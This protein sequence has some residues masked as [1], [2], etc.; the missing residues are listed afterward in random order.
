M[1]FDQLLAQTYEIGNP[2]S[3]VD[4]FDSPA[5]FAKFTSLER[6]LQGTPEETVVEPDPKN[7]KNQVQRIIPAKPPDWVRLERDCE[8]VWSQTR[9]LRVAVIIAV[10][11][12]QR[13]GF[14]GAR[15]ALDFLHKNIEKHWETIH[16]LQLG[17][18]SSDRFAEFN[19]LSTSL[20][21]DP[22]NPMLDDGKFVFH[23][24]RYRLFEVRGS[25]RVTYRDIENAR[26]GVREDD[27]PRVTR[28]EISTA[29]AKLTAVTRKQMIDAAA[30][31]LGTL[32]TMQSLLAKHKVRPNWQRM[33]RVLEG[34]QEVLDTKSVALA[35]PPMVP[36]GDETVMP[37]ASASSLPGIIRHRGEAIQALDAVRRYFENYE[38]SSPLLPMIERAKRLAS[39]S[40]LDAIKDLLPDSHENAQKSL[41]ISTSPEEEKD[42]K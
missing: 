31:M 21:D 28:E 30:G 25:V 22:P 14:S 3:G 10:V 13:E 18:D 2:D 42:N 29:V 40:F 6:Q 1:K 12:L 4:P 39:A 24:R 41:G 26:N 27:S 15:A 11:A 16:P 7:P 34:I 5:V 38:P 17:D 33:R 37:N 23:L 9:H 35:L 19:E 36:P 32:D 8:V 20:A